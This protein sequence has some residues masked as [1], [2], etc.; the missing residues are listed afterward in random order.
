MDVF[1]LCIG[2]SPAELSTTAARL[3]W[4]RN[5]LP[6][7]ASKQT[8]LL[9]LPELFATGYYIGDQIAARPELADWPTA[10]TI[11]TLAKAHN[12]AIHYGFA[13]TDGNN[14]FNSAQC[15]GPMGCA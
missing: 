5:I 7:A 13:E 2:Q 15:F 8:D 14:T 11:A 9:L 12:I 1:R 4:L 10:L 3:E 6:E